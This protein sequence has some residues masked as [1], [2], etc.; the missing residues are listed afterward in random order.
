IPAVVLPH[1]EGPGASGQ[2][3]GGLTD[4]LSRP[5]SPPMLRA[6]VRAWL[7]RKGALPMRKAVPLTSRSIAPSPPPS[8]GWLRGLPSRERNAFLDGSL[9][10]RFRPGETL[11]REGDPPGGVY[12]IRSGSVRLSVRLPDGRDRVLASA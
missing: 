2:L 9:H 5:F 6:R 10:C 4:V 8:K 3:V 11:F 1:A 7:T 12:F